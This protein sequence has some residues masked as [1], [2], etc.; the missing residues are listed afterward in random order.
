MS[1]KTPN[2]FK[3][4]SYVG[5]WLYTD[6]YITNG[7]IIIPRAILKDFI[8]YKQHAKTPTNEELERF[9]PKDTLTKEYKKTNRLFDY[10]HF[11]GRVFE[12]ENG[13]QLILNEDHIK[14]FK[15]NSVMAVTDTS[16]AMDTN[17]GIILMPLRKD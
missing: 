7:T 1:F 15:T 4:T 9:Y 2:R 5:G 13:E 6:K 3:C 17:T 8:E 12:S 10:C 14:Y 16:P 11:L